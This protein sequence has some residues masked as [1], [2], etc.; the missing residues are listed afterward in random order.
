VP[1]QKQGANFFCEHLPEFFVE[2]FSKFQVL[3]SYFQFLM[4]CGVFEL[5]MQEKEK[6]PKNAIKNPRSKEKK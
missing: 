4:V 2:T 6:R 1:S 5:L 3:F